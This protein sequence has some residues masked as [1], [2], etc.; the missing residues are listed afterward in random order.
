MIL[1]PNEVRRKE[2]LSDIEGGDTLFRPANLVPI[3]TPVAATKPTGGLGSD[4]TGEPA[5]GGDGGAPRLE[6]MRVRRFR[7]LSGARLR[8]Q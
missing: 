5:P 3:D 7:R 4:A 6:S 2:G 8:S 1:T